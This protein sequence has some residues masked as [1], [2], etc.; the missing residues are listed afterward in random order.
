MRGLM[1]CLFFTLVLSLFPAPATGQ[2]PTDSVTYKQTQAGP[3]QLLVTRPTDWSQGD[4]RSAIIFFF[5]GGFTT[6]SMDQF[7]RQAEYFAGRGMVAIRADYRVASRH[8]SEP[9]ASFEDARSA[10]RWVRAHAERLGVDPRRIV[11][12]GGSAGAHLAA[13]TAQCTIVAPAAEDTTASVRPNALVLFNPSVD[14]VHLPDPFATNLRT[15]PRLAQD[16]ALQRR[17]SPLAHV[18]ETGPPTLLLYGS[19]DPF[20]AQGRS[21]AD[22]LETE[23]VRTE[24]YLADGVGHGFFNDSPWLERTLQRVDQ[25]LGSLGYLTAT[26]QVQTGFLDRTIE[27]EGERYPYQV[28]VPRDFVRDRAWP[29]I[30]FLHGGSDSGTDGL[31]QT[32]EGL[33]RAIRAHPNWF[34]TLALFP[35]APQGKQWEGEVADA[36]IE[37]IDEVIAEFGVDAD[38]VFL[39]GISMG[40]MGVYE[41]AQRYPDRFAALLVISGSPFTPAWRLRDLDREPVDRSPEAFARVAE[42]LAH[43]PLWVFHGTEDDLADPE[44]ARS[45][46]RA[47]E[48]AGAQPRFTEYEGLGHDIWRRPIG[49]PSVW[50]WLL[51]QRRPPHQR[52]P[53]ELR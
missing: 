42:T 26:R 11:A 46:I 33:G 21:Y 24:L 36:V 38:A 12:A 22:A 6:G 34:P 8:H 19:D 2:L 44:E 35:Q 27:V 15:F 25:F 40:G 39:T 7:S 1:E 32:Q 31:R 48:A 13:C 17:I 28:Y 23:G 5:G 43:V 18:D 47:L 4:K 16:S 41:V 29:L 49:D 50:Q 53:R 9:D 20:L 3:L 45:V 30:V 37:E 52:V 51:S 14:L 10:V